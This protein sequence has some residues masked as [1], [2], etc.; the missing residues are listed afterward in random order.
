MV[1]LNKL[2]YWF[3]SAREIK[4]I[5]DRCDELICLAFPK[6]TTIMKRAKHI[7]QDIMVIIILIGMIGIVANQWPTIINWIFM[8]LSIII[9]GFVL[10]SRASRSSIK[11]CATVAKIL[12]YY[13]AFALIISISYHLITEP[14]FLKQTKLGEWFDNNYPIIAENMELIGLYHYGNINDPQRLWINFSSYL[15]YL[16]MGLILESIYSG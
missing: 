5:T 9:L 10:A 1:V 6:S 8:C 13:A 7:I 16:I 3:R 2:N 14:E 4:K 15:L 12:K 11:S